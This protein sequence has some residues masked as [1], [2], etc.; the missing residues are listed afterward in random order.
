[1]PILTKKTK[2]IK[3]DKTSEEYCKRCDAYLGDGH[4]CDN[5][6]YCGTDK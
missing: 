6:P 3:K 2:Q 1:M 5:C 4:D